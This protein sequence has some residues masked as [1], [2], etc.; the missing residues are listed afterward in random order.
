MSL[1][2]SL[3]DPIEVLGPLNHAKEELEVSKGWGLL[4]FCEGGN[5]KNCG[6]ARIGCQIPARISEVTLQPKL[7]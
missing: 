4:A 6:R 1:L 5:L 3:A 7:T 2:N